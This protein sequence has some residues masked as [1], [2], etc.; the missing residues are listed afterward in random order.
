MGFLLYFFANATTG[1]S[2]RAN[3]ALLENNAR[4]AAEVAVALAGTEDERKPEA[5]FL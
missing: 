3:V 4:V 5:E 1:R 2:L